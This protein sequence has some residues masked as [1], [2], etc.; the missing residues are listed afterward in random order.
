M[1]KALFLAEGETAPELCLCVDG[2]IDG[3][4]ATYSHWEGAVSPAVLL[5]DL[6]T[7]MLAIAAR[8]PDTY[9][10]PFEYVANNHVDT[11]GLLSM[12]LALD[13]SLIEFERLFIDA[14]AYGDFNRYNGENGARLAL[15]LHQAISEI[16][17]TGAGWEQRCFD[18][19][20]PNMRSYI[21]ESQQADAERDAQIDRIENAIVAIG[22]DNLHSE[23]HER[24]CVFVRDEEHGHHANDLCSVSV[25]DDMPLWAL[26]HFARDDQFLLLVLKNG[27]GNRYQLLAPTHSWAQTFDLPTVTWPDCAELCTE[28]QAIEQGAATWTT[29]PQSRDFD[30]TCILTVTTTDDQASVAVS[31]IPVDDVVQR[32]CDV[33]G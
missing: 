16:R 7:G 17:D 30:F 27:N 21:V 18:E 14:A 20:L 25:E 28:L 5:H 33:L 26:N 15:R 32:I 9:L 6:S 3:A 11:D 19:I 2:L 10:R 31:S 13:P 22:S 24:L 1:A 29:L 4:A 8:E 12:A 23:E